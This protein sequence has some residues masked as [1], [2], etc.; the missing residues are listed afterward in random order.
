M[1]TRKDSRMLLL[2]INVILPNHMLVNNHCFL[3]QLAVPV[4]V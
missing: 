3:V 4:I 2:E 1:T